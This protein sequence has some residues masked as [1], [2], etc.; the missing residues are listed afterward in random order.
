MGQIL[1]AI[2]GGCCSS[3][4]QI[5]YKAFLSYAQTREYIETLTDGGLLSY[6]LTSQTFKLTEEGMR[7]LR[8]YDEIDDMINLAQ[9]S[10]QGQYQAL[11]SEEEIGSHKEEKR[12]EVT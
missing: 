9:L 12:V 6:E 2:N 11:I 3:K 7:F 8:I 5:M 4:S 10:E 1:Q